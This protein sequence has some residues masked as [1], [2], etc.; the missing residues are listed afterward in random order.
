MIIPVKLKDIPKFSR[1]PL[2]ANEFSHTTLLGQAYCLH[3]EYPKP[4][5]EYFIVT[6]DL[7]EKE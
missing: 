7:E 1:G 2:T 3:H 4:Y 5:D 6:K